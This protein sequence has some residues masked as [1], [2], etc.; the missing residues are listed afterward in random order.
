M[1]NGRAVAPPPPLPSSWGKLLQRIADLTGSSVP[2]PN[3]PPARPEHKGSV[4]DTGADNASDTDSDYESLDSCSDQDSIV[5]DPFEEPL[6]ADVLQLIEQSL[7]E[8]K[9]G[10]LRCFK[11]LIPDQLTARVAEDLLRLASSEPC[12]L[13]GAVIDLN[14]EDDKLFRNVDRFAVDGSLSPT[15][16][17]TLVLRL[18]AGLWPKIQDLF[19]SGPSFTPGFRRALRLS[20]GFR[21]IKRKLYSPTELVIEQC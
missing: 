1:C 12:G 21:I 16:E 15:F 2:H 11:L 14:V 13:R 3:L 10:A 18:E 19:T 20:P 5:D 6:C 17:L 7:M 9:R 8:A 4:C